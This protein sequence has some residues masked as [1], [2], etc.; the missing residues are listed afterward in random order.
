[1]ITRLEDKE[2][3]KSLINHLSFSPISKDVPVAAAIYDE[4]LNIVSISRN[5]KEVSFDP[6][7][8]AEIIALRDASQKVKNW[9]LT[10]FSLYVTL[11]PCLM[12]A[13]AILPS[14]ISRVIF[15]AFSTEEFE[16]AKEIL[17]KTNP[18]LEVIGG[19]YG[20]ECAEIISQWFDNQRKISR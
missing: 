2:I 6:T 14:R 15:G 5:L 20:E 9:N 18:K 7:A 17:R 8:H 1:M 10:E 12:C 3:I 11:E 16:T 4:D 19:V 13:G